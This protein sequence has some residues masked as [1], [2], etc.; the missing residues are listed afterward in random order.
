MELIL[1]SLNRLK[2]ENSVLDIHDNVR[3]PGSNTKNNVVFIVRS[4]RLQWKGY[5]NN[6]LCIL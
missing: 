4:Y 3:K 1:N 5:R 6:M 2:S